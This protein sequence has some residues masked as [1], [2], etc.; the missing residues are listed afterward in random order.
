MLKLYSV[1]LFGV[2]GVCS[3]AIGYAAGQISTIPREEIDYR[4]TLSDIDV[5]KSFGF[6]PIDTSDGVLVLQKYNITYSIESCPMSRV[7]VDNWD[8]LDDATKL[9]IVQE[10]QSLGY[11]MEDN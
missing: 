1:L 6:C 10:L 2:L 11:R 9:L 5:R 7:Y 8:K 3:V 4:D